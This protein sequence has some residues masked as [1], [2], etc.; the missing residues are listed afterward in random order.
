MTIH[1]NKYETY[2]T[3]DIRG[4]AFRREEGKTNR[5]TICGAYKLQFMII[6]EYN[7]FIFI[8]KNAIRGKHLHVKN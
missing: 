3:N 7:F 2:L 4:V 6:T 1:P 5:Q 8:Y